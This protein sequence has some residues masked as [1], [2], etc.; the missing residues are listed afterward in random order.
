MSKAEQDRHTDVTSARMIRTMLLTDAPSSMTGNKT[1]TILI[2]MSVSD[3]SVI[4]NTAIL[5]DEQIRPVV[6]QVQRCLL[7]GE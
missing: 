6:A 4:L 7:K 1:S 2:D 5:R 3:Y